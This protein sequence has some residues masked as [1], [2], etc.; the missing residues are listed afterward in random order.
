M[1][2]FMQSLLEP[3]RQVVNR[4]HNTT[5]P[6]HLEPPPPPHIIHGSKRPPHLEPSPLIGC[7]VLH[8]PLA[9]N[10]PPPLTSAKILEFWPKFL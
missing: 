9:S 2:Y 8:G 6:P 4:M 10:P 5:R 3:S 7:M 1:P